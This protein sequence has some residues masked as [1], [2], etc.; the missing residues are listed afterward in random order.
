MFNFHVVV[1]H[2]DTG[3]FQSLRYTSKNEV[4]TERDLMN[5]EEFHADKS[6]GI[7]DIKTMIVSWQ[8]LDT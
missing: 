6:N 5:I 2:H 8:R 4:L 1:R 7:K 3:V